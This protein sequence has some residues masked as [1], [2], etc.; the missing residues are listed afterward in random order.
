[1]HRCLRLCSQVLK[2]D[3]LKLSESTFHRRS[4]VLQHRSSATANFESPIDTISAPSHPGALLAF[5]SDK[6]E[7]PLDEQHRFPM[8]KYRLTR[9]ALEADPSING[10]IEIREVCIPGM[11]TY[12][13]H[14]LHTLSSSC[15]SKL[16]KQL[17][18]ISCVSGTTCNRG[19]TRS[20]T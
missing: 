14:L 1:M 16:L 19:R 15:A 10:L 2:K 13:Y 8:S 9:L 17:T 5:H 18:V 20:C 6:H 12:E 7:V 11:A 3:S 4:D